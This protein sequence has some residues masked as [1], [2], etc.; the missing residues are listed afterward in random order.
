MSDGPVAIVTAAGQGIGE[1]VARVLYARGYRLGLMSPS[2]RS[3]KLAAEL[4]QLGLA[5]SITTTDDLQTLVNATLDRFG[6]IDAVVNNAGHLPATDAGGG[7]SYDP[8]Y[9]RELIDITDSEWLVGVDMVFLSIVR[10]SRLVAPVMREQGGGSIV[11]ISTFSAPEPRLTYP[12][13]SSVRGAVAGYMKMF[14]D[15]YARD[16]IRMN[17]VLPGFIDNWPL[18]GDVYRHVP[19]RRAG[20]REEVANTV[21]FLLS[22]QASYITGQSILVDGGV[23]RSV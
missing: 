23:N 4:G 21:A 5:G 8:D 15:R 17:S 18:G 2:S 11:N 16:G 13:S 10:M 19:T 1:T 7:P 20:T 9:A 6:K 3:A 12:I 22:P 14:S